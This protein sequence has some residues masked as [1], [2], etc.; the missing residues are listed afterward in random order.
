[1]PRWRQYRTKIQWNS[2][3][4]ARDIRLPIDRF[5]LF[6]IW[7]GP[8]FGQFWMSIR[9]GVAHSGTK[10]LSCRDDLGAEVIVAPPIYRSNFIGS[11]SQPS[12]CDRSKARG[13]HSWETA[14]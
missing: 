12:S 7:A 3:A 2:G 5:S 9:R 13:Q 14:T 4:K 8:G 11:E 1:M 6:G 10:S